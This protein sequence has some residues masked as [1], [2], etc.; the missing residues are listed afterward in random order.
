MKTAIVIPARYASTRLLGKMLLEAAGKPLIRHVWENA[1]RARLAGQVVIATD[2]RRIF[3]AARGFGAQVVMTDP[4]H[5]T[6]T[7]RVAE[8]A[9]S[10][11]ADI[12][13]NVQGDEP[14][15]DPDS[16]DRLIALQ[17]RLSPYASTLACP[18]P[19]AA[20][21]EDP[22]AV[23]AVLGRLL[24]VAEPA[25]EAVYFTRALAPFPRDGA[26]ARENYFLHI[27]VYAFRRDALFAFAA[28]PEGRLERIERLEQLRILEM[29]ERIHAAIVPASSPGIDT[30][31][32]F[33]AFKARVERKQGP[34]T[35]NP[36]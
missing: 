21:L 8:A 20:R 9:R 12:V 33:E 10:M 30:P 11:D 13:V 5:K 36:G 27:G 28:A 24:P 35:K 14:E 19:A 31:Q 16:L 26:P 34:S 7:E 15:I 22:A 29:G 23:K 3:D 2:D 6:G 17:M 4:R 18:F 25:R 32:D 1:A